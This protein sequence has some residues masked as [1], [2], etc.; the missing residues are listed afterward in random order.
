VSKDK[1]YEDE[2]ARVSRM[3][4]ELDWDDHAHNLRVLDEAIR[5]IKAGLSPARRAQ[6]E[7]ESEQ[8]GKPMGQ[9]FATEVVRVRETHGVKAAVRVSRTLL[10]D[11]ARSCGWSESA[12][13]RRWKK[14][15]PN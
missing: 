2:L 6:L 14:P 7:R 12:I 5:V 1:K 4:D 11:L 9:T 10:A 15:P 13:D 8:V 3:I